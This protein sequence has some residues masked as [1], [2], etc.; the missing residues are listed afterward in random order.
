MSQH[1]DL[2]LPRYSDS[3]KM[4]I[5]C[6]YQMPEILME[7]NFTEEMFDFCYAI[8][9]RKL[10]ELISENTKPEWDTVR[11]SFSPSELEEIGGIESLSSILYFALVP[12]EWRFHYKLL[13]EGYQRRKQ[14]EFFSRHLSR[15]YHLGT[16]WEEDAWLKFDP[17]IHRR[18]P[19]LKTREQAMLAI[20]EITDRTKTS[21]R[22]YL[23]GLDRLDQML[24]YVRPGNVIVIAAQTSLGKSAMAHNIAVHASLNGNSKKVAVFSMEMTQIE[25]WERIFSSQCAVLMR[26]IREQKVSLEHR[27]KMEKFTHEKVPDGYPLMI[28]DESIQEVGEIVSRCKRYKK[29]YGLDLVIVDYLQLISPASA[30]KES[31]RQIE[32][33]TV[34]RKLKV[35]AKDLGV[36]VVS[37]SQLNDQNQLRES[38]AIGQDADVVMHIVNPEEGSK[39][40]RRE[41]HIR[42]SRNG[43]IGNVDVDFFPPYASFANRPK[44]A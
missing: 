20:Q 37:L 31:N 6:I 17:G 2:T 28:V 41:I 27:I 25:V 3:E 13:L 21:G 40:S 44:E 22:M 12:E 5:S 4:A 38:R 39:E 11:T 29:N 15:C 7:E 26:D 14:I 32:V 34:S 30:G 18:A 9:F 42:K 10:C 33:A 23:T 35:M 24:G 16:P 36:V 43:E 19:E 8:I 1:A